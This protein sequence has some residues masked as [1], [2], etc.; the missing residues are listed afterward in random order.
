MYKILVDDL[1]LYDPL[2]DE[3]RI[4]SGKVDLEV[5]KAGSLTFSIPEDN[6]HYGLTKLMKSNVVLYDDDRVIFKGRPYAPSRNLFRDNEIICEGALTFFNDSIQDPFDY[7][8]TVEGLFRQVITRHNS[9]VDASRQFKIGVVNVVNSTDSGNITRSSIEYMT[10]WEL[11]RDKFFE[12]ALGGYLWVRYENDGTYI[13]YRND[14]NFICDQDVEQSINLVDVKESVSCAELATAVIPLGAKV[15]DVYTTIESVNGGIKYLYDE[16]AVAEYGWIFKIVKHDNIYDKDILLRTGRQDLADAVGVTTTIQVKAS[17]LS[18]AGYDVSP[19]SFGTYVNV[20]IDNLNIDRK[21]LIKKLSL[22][23]LKPESSEITVGDEIKSFTNNYY[24]VVNNNKNDVIRIETEVE[25]LKD[26]EIGGRNL[27]LNSNTFDGDNIS[28]NSKATIEG[29]YRGLQV[30]SHDNSSA[31]SGYADILQFKSIYPEKL[32][33]TY[34]FS[35]YA[36]GSGMITTYFYGASGFLQCAD[37][38]QSNGT[39]RHAGDGASDWNLTDEWVRYWVTWTLKNEGDISIEKY[40]LFR[41]YFGGKVDICGCKLEKGDKATTYTLAPEDVEKDYNGKN[42]DINNSII[43]LSKDLTAEI[44][45]TKTSITSEVAE[46]YYTKDETKTLVSE[47]ST[48]LEQTKNSFDF[49]FTNYQTDLDSL[50]DGTNAEFTEIKKMIRF[51]DGKIKLGIEGDE[52]E[53][54]LQNNRLYFS[55]NGAEVAYFSNS[56]LY[57][58]DAEILASLRIGKFAFIPRANGSLDFKKVGD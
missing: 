26:L 14:L 4:L 38:V 57:I 35:F 33:D 28:V 20:I 30:Y 10:T 29:V 54:T 13:D 51:V 55:Q 53:L 11:L 18:K 45:K 31:T 3:Y 39:I 43:E 48:K 8:G 56:K 41:L 32:G 58:T 15:D 6:P 27:L 37:V 23:L 19:F 17:D 5:N 47:V 22:D 9:Q 36:K 49:T 7:F 25:N 2:L 24:G 16:E 21:M 50:R 34:T 42:D 12:S 52:L 1:T 46:K 40:V 44:T